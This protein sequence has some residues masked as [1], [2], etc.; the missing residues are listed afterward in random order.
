M[1]LGGLVPS[2]IEVRSIEREER[3]G[4]A[5]MV[6]LGASL[7]DDI[8]WRHGRPFIKFLVVES[9]SL[10]VPFQAL[11]LSST[12]GESLLSPRGALG[13]LKQPYGSLAIPNPSGAVMSLENLEHRL[14]LKRTLQLTS[15]PVWRDAPC[16]E[17]NYRYF[18][19][20]QL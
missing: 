2:L 5:A 19:S 1:S 20:K 9:I 17:T 13:L 4:R 8:L 11:C 10:Y 18:V 3:G 7:G 14:S 16:R 15:V 6:L 12:R